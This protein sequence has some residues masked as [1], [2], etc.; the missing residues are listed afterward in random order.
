MSTPDFDSAF[1][2]L[3]AS[4]EPDRYGGDWPS[5][6]AMVTSFGFNELAKVSIGAYQGDTS[7]LLRDGDRYGYLDFGWGSCSGCDALEACDSVA[8]I[9]KLWTGL[10]S[11]IRW[12]DTAADAAE[13][14]RSHDWEADY[15]NGPELRA[16]VAEALGWLSGAA[17]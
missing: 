12:F 4:P 15:N 17:S 14:F 5:Y 8:D 7:Y 2:A 9:R 10:L 1:P 3:V 13:F 6:E 11:G 16:F